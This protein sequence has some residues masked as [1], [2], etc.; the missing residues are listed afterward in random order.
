MLERDRLGACG[1][2]R[3][4]GRGSATA[5]GGPSRPSR[6]RSSVVIARPGSG[7]VAASDVA[8]RVRRSARRRGSRSGRSCRSGSRTRRRASSRPRARDPTARS[9]ATGGRRC[10]SR[11]RVGRA[12][13]PG[14]DMKQSTSAPSSVERARRLREGLVVTDQH[15]DPA[16]RRVERGEA[17]AGRRDAALVERHVDLAVQ[18]EQPVAASRTRRRCGARRP[19]RPRRSRRRRPCRRPAP[20]RVRSSGPSGSSAGGGST[21]PL[22]RLDVAAERGL[23]QDEQA[24]ARGA[25]LVDEARRSSR[26][27]ASRSRS[28]GAAAAAMGQHARPNPVGGAAPSAVVSVA[29]GPAQ[30][31]AGLGGQRAAAR[32]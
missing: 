7:P 3:G 19:R 20:S 16:D 15:P 23:G 9:G 8:V 1:R 2:R 25:G 28:K 24:R 6:C 21:S 17:V 31:H 10:R 12:A 13:R 4:A 14:A 5:R 11:R 27:C 29:V 18:A 22:Q 26:S 32:R 30:A